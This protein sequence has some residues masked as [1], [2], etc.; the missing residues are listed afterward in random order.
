MASPAA[1]GERRRRR[2]CRGT[3]PVQAIGRPPQSLS[4]KILTLPGL[5]VVGLSARLLKGH[6]KQCPATLYEHLARALLRRSDYYVLNRPLSALDPRTQ[7]ATARAVVERLRAQ[8]AGVA[9]VLPSAAP[10]MQFDRVAVFAAGRLA[11]SG[12][13]AELAEKNG[14]F[15]DM[16]K[17]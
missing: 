10:A 14:I 12:R 9:W 15:A 7:E 5:R 4:A 8:G 16:I 6:I 1:G 13:P 3:G 11:E 2:R 17:S